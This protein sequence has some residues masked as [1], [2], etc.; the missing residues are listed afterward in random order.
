MFTTLF[1]EDTDEEENVFGDEEEE[2]ELAA[3]AT[4]NLCL[5]LDDFLSTMKSCSSSRM[6]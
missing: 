6:S 1:P 3:L 4:W 5:L 2:E